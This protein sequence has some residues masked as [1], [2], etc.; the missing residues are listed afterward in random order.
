MARKG[1]IVGPFI[2]VL[3][4]MDSYAGIPTQA[5]CSNEAISFA[6]EYKTNVLVYA[7]VKT[8]YTH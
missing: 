6:K 8:V 1:F 2:A 5:E 3:V 7:L 4:L